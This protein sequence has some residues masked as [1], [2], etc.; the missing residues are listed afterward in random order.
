MLSR[1]LFLSY[2][3]MP[4]R[5]HVAALGSLLYHRGTVGDSE[6]PFGTHKIHHQHFTLLQPSCVGPR[7]SGAEFQ[8]GSGA[9]AI[10]AFSFLLNIP[11]ISDFIPYASL[12]EGWPRG[13]LR[14][15]WEP[16]RALPRL[17]LSSLFPHIPYSPRASMPP[18]I[19]KEMSPSSSLWILCSEWYP[20]CPAPLGNNTSGPSHKGGRGYRKRF[21]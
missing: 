3:F 15:L 9:Q 19:L 4:H 20:P 10:A 16:T 5:E 21:L 1:S 13:G 17:I 8:T 11:G 18:S 12:G 2:F 6:A 7:H 14:P